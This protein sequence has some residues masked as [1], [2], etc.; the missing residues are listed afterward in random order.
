[1]VR[2]VPLFHTF[3]AATAA[4]EIADDIAGVLVGAHHFDFHDRFEQHGLPLPDG[5]FHA[6]DAA[7]WNAISDES[8]S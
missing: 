8:T 7:V 5:F 2:V 4:V 6:I 1:M 3:H